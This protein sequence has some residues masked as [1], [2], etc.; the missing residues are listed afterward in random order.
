MTDAKAILLTK[1]SRN[2]DDRTPFIIAPLWMDGR[3]DGQLHPMHVR[4]HPVLGD[5]V[6]QPNVCHSSSNDVSRTAFQ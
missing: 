3:M 1:I 5:Y 4:K 2:D 6:T